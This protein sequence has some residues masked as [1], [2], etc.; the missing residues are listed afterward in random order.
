ME[1]GA[2][3]SGFALLDK[4]LLAFTVYCAPDRLPTHILLTYRFL[5]VMDK[6]EGAAAW[7]GR[8]QMKITREQRFFFC[9]ILL[10]KP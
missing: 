1:N 2:P 4:H 10:K 7:M 8:G 6:R 5:C 9:F 3:E